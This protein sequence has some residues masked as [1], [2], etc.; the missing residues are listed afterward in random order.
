LTQDHLEQCKWSFAASKFMGSHKKEDFKISN[1]LC[2]YLDVL[3]FAIR[4]MYKHARSE[5]LIDWLIDGD[6][7]T[8]FCLR[9]SSACSERTGHVTDLAADLRGRCTHSGPDLALG[10]LSSRSME[11]HFRCNHRP[12]LT[13]S[14]CMEIFLALCRAILG[15]NLRC[16]ELNFRITRF[17]KGGTFVSWEKNRAQFELMLKLFACVREGVTSKKV[18]ICIQWVYCA[19]LIKIDRKAGSNLVSKKLSCMMTQVMSRKSKIL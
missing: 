1:Y 7:V 14:K 3:W 15:F 2:N 11:N 6:G 17:V 12:H 13:S 9:P 5:Q 16:V 19:E 8:Q 4:Q 18:A 10:A